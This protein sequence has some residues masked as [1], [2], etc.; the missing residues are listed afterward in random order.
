MAALSCVWF[1]SWD[2]LPWLRFFLSAL[3]NLS[4]F[5]G[6]FF[7]HYIA[8]VCIS[9]LWARCFGAHI[10]R[11]QSWKFDVVKFLRNSCTLG[12]WEFT[13]FTLKFFWFYF[14]VWLAVWFMAAKFIKQ[15]WWFWVLHCLELF[16]LFFW[17]F[18]NRYW[19]ELQEASFFWFWLFLSWK[20]LL[21]WRL[22]ERKN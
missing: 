20:L 3:C 15:C 22:C 14:F 10:K 19:M 16:I 11:N 4:L 7:F 9:I 5:L 21:T 6:S 13:L 12:I 17:W 8:N 2:V 1:L 18:V